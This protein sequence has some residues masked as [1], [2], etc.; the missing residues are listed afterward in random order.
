MQGIIGGRCD[1][2]P[3]RASNR[4]AVVGAC[5]VSRSEG[6]QILVQGG[7]AE[8]LTVRSAQDNLLHR[9]KAQRSLRA[10]V[11]KGR[12]EAVLV[13]VVACREI[14]FQIL[15]K[16]DGG[17]G[18]DTVDLA[19]AGDAGNRPGSAHLIATGEHRE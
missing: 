2:H 5:V 15:V 14:K 17:L 12:S 13:V 1:R 4:V 3:T 6:T 18:V 7:S 9:L 10:E 8:P 16:R 19:V 11:V